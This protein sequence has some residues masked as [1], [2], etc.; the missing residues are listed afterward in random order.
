M[1]HSN[2]RHRT[3][4]LTVGYEPQIAQLISVV[5]QA[6]KVTQA[7]VIRAA[8]EALIDQASNQRRADDPPTS[9]PSA[10][11]YRRRA[12]TRG[13]QPRF[14]ERLNTYL[15]GTTYEQL[16]EYCRQ[17]QLNKSRALRL[18]VDRYLFEEIRAAGLGERDFSTQEPNE[19][20]AAAAAE[21]GT[22]RAADSS[23]KGKGK[24]RA[25]DRRGELVNTG[26]GGPS[27]RHAKRK[28]SG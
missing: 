8:V 1:S 19:H 15:D 7:E 22:S 6:K 21:Q 10:A 3:V 27:G 9:P 20:Q 28:R 13:P 17:E 26:N 4:G 14:T 5:S 16:V 12:G 25:E 2:P 18:A 11:V 24:H 23:S